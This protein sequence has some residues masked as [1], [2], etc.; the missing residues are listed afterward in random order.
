VRWPIDPDRVDYE[1]LFD[2]LGRN[3]S[4]THVRVQCAAD[5]GTRLVPIVDFILTTEQALKA[6]RRLRID[7][8]TVAPILWRRHH[9]FFARLTDWHPARKRGHSSLPR[10][11]AT[12]F[13][14]PNLR[15]DFGA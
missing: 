5:P 1:G 3:H 8:L 11:S 7:R 10:P 13:L 9:A 4:R 2:A 12:S 6:G 14:P 15:V